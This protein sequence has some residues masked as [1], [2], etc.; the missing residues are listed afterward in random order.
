MPSPTVSVPDTVAYFVQGY[1]TKKDYTWNVNGNQPPKQTT[2]DQT[3]RWSRRG[4][5]FITVVYAPGDPVTGGGLP[6]TISVTVD[7]T[8]DDIKTETINVD[9]AVR[10]AASSQVARFG[11]FS[12]LT[13]LAT[14][15][16]IAKV[17]GQTGST[18]SLFAPSNAAFASG[19]NPAGALGANPTQAVDADEKATSSV[20]ADLLKYH[21]VKGDSLT[22]GDLPAN[23]VQTLLGNTTVSVTA[24]MVAQANIPATNGV[25]HKLNTPLLPPTA[26]VDFTDRTVDTLSAG[27]GGS[28]PDTLTVD[29]SFIPEGGGFIV[30]HDSTELQNQ[31]AL[32]SIVGKSGYLSPNMVKNKVKVP[33]D[34]TISDTTSIGAMPHEDTNGNQTYDFET[35]AGS[36]DTP[37]TLGGAP[38]LDYGV[39]KID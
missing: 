34:E 8:P 24:D 1:T 12:T 19:G 25:I 6:G 11:V 17:L 9:A 37:Y 2:A 18:F 21:A 7:A 31:G 10:D 36:Q 39:V 23:N 13:N 26:S 4:G 22:S 27:G 20:T 28:A 16:G 29:G 38:V 15:S 30:L 35:S 14:T 33:L 3:Y 5:E 32:A